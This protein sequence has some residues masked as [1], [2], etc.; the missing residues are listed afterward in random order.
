MQIK[1]ILGVYTPF[2]LN[3]LARSIKTYSRKVYLSFYEYTIPI[4]ALLI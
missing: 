4:L 2:C 3:F 1:A